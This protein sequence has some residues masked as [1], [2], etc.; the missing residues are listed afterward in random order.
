MIASDIKKI[1]NVADSI[2]KMMNESDAVVAQ[3]AAKTGLTAQMNKILADGFFF[4]FKAHTFHWNVTGPNFNDYHAFFGKVYEQVF[5]S[6][7]PIAE[8]IRALGI[9][10]P[11]SL[12]SLASITTIAPTTSIPSAQ[13]M[14]T[15]LI[16][17]NNKILAGLTTGYKLA[18]AAG[19]PG[20][21]NFLQ[22]LID[23]HKKLAWMLESTSK[24][25]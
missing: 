15:I 11:T 10:A 16:D 18:D 6:L 17:D 25:E 3:T 2:R 12:Q 13:Q 4:Y 23:K 21:S 9:M 7:D 5:D 14:F 19:E 8:E 1:R 22:D 20:L 24:G